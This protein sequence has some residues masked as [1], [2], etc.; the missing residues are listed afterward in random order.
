MHNLNNC[1]WFEYYTNEYNTRIASNS[2]LVIRN[3]LTDHSRQSLMYG[4]VKAWNAIPLD[5]R[6]ASSYNSFKYKLKLHLLD[7]GP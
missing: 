3:V 6:R 5:V 4:G 2:N 1:N 7:N